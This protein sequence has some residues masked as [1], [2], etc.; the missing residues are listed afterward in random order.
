MS[1]IYCQD[2]VDLLFR[3]IDTE[4]N[5]QDKNGNTLLHLLIKHMARLSKQHEH[6]AEE[7]VLRG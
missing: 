5:R 1:R 4:K 3:F 7:L 6:F 2:A